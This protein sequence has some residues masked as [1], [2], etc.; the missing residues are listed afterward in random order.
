[1]SLVDKLRFDADIRKSSPLET[2]DTC[3]REVARIYDESETIGGRKWVFSQLRK[4]R[5][6]QATKTLIPPRGTDVTR[7]GYGREVAT[8]VVRLAGQGTPPEVLKDMVV[9]ALVRLDPQDAQSYQVESRDA[10]VRDLDPTRGRRGIVS[11]DRF[12]DIGTELLDGRSYLDRILG[13]CALTGRRTYEVGC[14]GTFTVD[15]RNSVIF[16]GQAKMRGRD[17]LGSY[18][19]PT[20]APAAKIV[21]TM[22]TIREDRPDLRD[23][24][25]E[26]FHNRCAKDLHKRSGVFAPVFTD[27]TAKPKDLRPAW[28]E[29]AWLLIDERRTGKA[30]FLSRVLGHG[31]QDLLTAQSYDDFVIADPEY[32]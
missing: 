22:A 31:D 10:V 14:T 23:L 8:A 29:I 17:S 4:G 25:S 26:A 28:A 2:V 15:G 20:L 32:A 18:V 11:V 6:P 30:L 27:G 13:I 24:S 7:E 9:L 3:L 1:M 12:V 19:V 5:D 16:S 21:A